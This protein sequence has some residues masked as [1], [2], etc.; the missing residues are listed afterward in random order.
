MREDVDVGVAEG[1]QHADAR[2]APHQAVADGEA[3]P[4]LHQVRERGRTGIE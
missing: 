3:R 1:G 4:V 2:V